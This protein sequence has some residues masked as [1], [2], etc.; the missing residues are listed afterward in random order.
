MRIGALVLAALA[1][2]ACTTTAL[3]PPMPPA[4]PG[5]PPPPPP[6]P[7]VATLIG[8]GAYHL[9]SGAHGD[10]AGMSVV[11]MHDTPAYRR[12]MIAL[13]GS[14][15]SARLATAAVKARSARLGPPAENPLAA[16]V[17]CQAGGRFAFH[18]I[19][20]GSYFIIVRVTAVSARG[21]T[22]DVVVMRHVDLVD[23]QTHEV[24]LAP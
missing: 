13:Y 24:S 2:S 20:G 10:C 22:E 21:A 17:E 7:A 15:E 16:S 18:D 9:P 19:A 23:G 11:L 3:G 6:P 4:P 14:A 12:R 5:P 8:H 1:V